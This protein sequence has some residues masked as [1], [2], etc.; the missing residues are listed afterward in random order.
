MVLPAVYLS[1]IAIAWK[2]KC[3]KS[4]QVR[5][6]LFPTPRCL[7]SNIHSRVSKWHLRPLGTE[8]PIESIENFLLPFKPKVATLVAVI[9]K[10]ENKTC[11][12]HAL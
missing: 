1:P 12:T 5:Q 10:T 7:S 2:I 8:G 6:L 9:L 11:A 3:P 4:T